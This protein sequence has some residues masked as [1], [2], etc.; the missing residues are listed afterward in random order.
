M[1]TR[2]YTERC[3][4]PKIGWA[5]MDRLTGIKI[6]GV[7]YPHCVQSGYASRDQ[8]EFARLRHW[9]EIVR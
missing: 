1:K 2:F 3:L 5:V 8:A 4:D 6:E 9:P 7:W